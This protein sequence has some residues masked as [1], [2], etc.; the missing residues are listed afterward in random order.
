MP[1]KMLQARLTPRQRDILQRVVEEYVATGQPVGSKN[2]VERSQLSVSASTVRSELAE[3]EVRGFLTHPHTS[4][5]RI[6]T[7]G[8][9]RAYVDALLE[10]LEPRPARFELDLSAVRSEVEAALQATTEMLADVTSLLALVSAPPLETTT[11]RHAEVLLLQPR[12]VV[13]VVITSTGGVSKRV[14]TFDE[15][16]D[17]G[18][19]SWAAEYL[20]E[21]VAGLRLGTHL[22]RQRFEDPELTARE[23]GFLERLRPPFT[24]LLRAEQRLY[25]GGAA[26]LLD[27]VRVDELGV[28]RRL[29]DALEKRVALLELVDEALDPKRLF[30]RVGGELANPALQDV[31]LVAACYGL[32]NRPLGTVGL[33]GPVRMDYEKAIRSVRSAAHELS[34]F[35]EDV[36]A[37]N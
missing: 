33:L 12:V 7:E 10:R 24:E 37:E 22:L 35:V 19:A 34:R 23:R 5:G 11:V 14:V 30:V 6:P 20:D 15:P 16:V 13:V 3:L 2:L 21:R 25:V 32:S 18:L 28:Y 4:A 36:Y 1:A 26:S 31:A 29:L 27:D 17:P 9:Y 8:G